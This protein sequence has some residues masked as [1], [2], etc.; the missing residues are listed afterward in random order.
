MQIEHIAFNV[1]DPAGM[2]AWYGQHLGMRMIRKIDGVTNT[3]FLADTV[4]RVVLELYHQAKAPIPDYAAQDP[5]VLHVAYVVADVRAER[6]R[7]L[8]AGAQ[9]V[10][11]IAV[12]EGGDELAMLRDPW[13]F[14]VQLVRRAK[15]MM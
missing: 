13:G 3:H 10:G 11:E 6:Q 12:N 9:P 7:L 5:M 8:A 15:K 14:A 4:G 1:S 2:A